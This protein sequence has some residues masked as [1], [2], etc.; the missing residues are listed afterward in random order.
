MG[1]LRLRVR[2]SSGAGQAMSD[3]TDAC[4]FFSTQLYPPAGQKEVLCSLEDTPVVTKPPETPG[5]DLKSPWT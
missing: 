5:P 2:G 4:S 3:G 1:E